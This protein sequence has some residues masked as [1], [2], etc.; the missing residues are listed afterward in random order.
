MIQ[1]KAFI[2]YKMVAWLKAEVK[3]H[4]NIILQS[5]L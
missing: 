1:A 4:S 3:G 2:T 5:F